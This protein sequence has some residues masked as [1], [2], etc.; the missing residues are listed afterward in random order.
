VIGCIYKDAAGRNHMRVARTSAKTFPTY[1][2]DHGAWVPGWP[3][4]VVP[5]RL[6]QLIAA[7][8]NEPVWICEGEKDANNVAALG[9]IA[10]TNPGGAGKWQHELT[11]W[12]KGKEI[13]MGSNKHFDSHR[14]TDVRSQLM[15]LKRFAEEFVIGISAITHPPKNASAQALD[16]FIG[17]QAFI[18][19]ARIGHLCLIEMEED[20]D[21]KRIPTGRRL[22][23]NPKINIEARQPT[24]AYTVNVVDVEPDEETGVM[25]RAPVIQWEGEVAITAE[26]ALAASRPTRGKERK[27][28]MV[29]E[30]LRHILTGGPVLAA[31]IKAQAATHGFSED[32]LR[33]ARDRLS[34]VTL[35][36]KTFPAG[37]KWALPQHAP[38]PEERID[39]L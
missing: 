30:F 1:R 25:I 38:S 11:Q 32:Q 23:T 12:F 13:N 26:E 33:S 17:S 24:L 9:L 22:F 4:H 7:P 21:G 35:R 27:T 5:Y 6:P 34:V 37:T 36:D 8:S 2:W 3:E 18:A 16:H 20:E 14:A 10:T 28:A 15:P 29:D 19:T 39:D 31:V